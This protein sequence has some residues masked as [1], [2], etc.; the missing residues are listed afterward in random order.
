MRKIAEK[1]TTFTGYVIREDYDLNNLKKYG[2]YKPEPDICPWWQK[3]FNIVWNLFGTW[4][5][6]LLVNRNDR[7]LLKKVKEG[8]NTDDLQKTLDKMISDGVF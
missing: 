6:E 2:F 4:D 5:T 8:S 3:P 1:I 7:K